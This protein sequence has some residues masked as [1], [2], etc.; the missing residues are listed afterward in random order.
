MLIIFQLFIEAQGFY[1]DLVLNWVLVAYAHRLERARSE[2]F[3]YS[4][5]LA[6][7][8][9]TRQGIPEGQNPL[10][11]CWPEKTYDRLINSRCQMRCLLLL[12]LTPGTRKKTKAVWLS[13]TF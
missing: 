4:W 12:V 5:A 10:Q 8:E 6:R 3:R 11:A 1:T 2:M 7:L 13:V 9:V